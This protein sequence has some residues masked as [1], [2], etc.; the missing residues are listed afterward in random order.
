MSAFQRIVL[1]LRSAGL[2][3]TAIAQRIHSTPATI[4]H[5]ARGEIVDPRW[6]TGL[7][8]LTL[9]HKHCRDA[10]EREVYGRF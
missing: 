5:I 8:L 10:H 2:S 6:S 3:S 1:N 4:N 9:H 7:G